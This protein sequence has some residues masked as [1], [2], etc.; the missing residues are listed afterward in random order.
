MVDL[1]KDLRSN[2]AGHFSIYVT[3]CIELAAC[4]S[5]TNASPPKALLVARQLDR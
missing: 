5:V 2:G 4:L 1:Y 3:F